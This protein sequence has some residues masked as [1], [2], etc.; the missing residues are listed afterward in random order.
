[1]TVN[2]VAMVSMIIVLDEEASADEFERFMLLEL[3]PTVDTGGE[4]EEPD[5]H[6]LLMDRQS[7]R[8]YTWSARLNYSI[9]QTPTPDWLLNRVRD[10]HAAASDRVSPFGTG[11]S[12]ALLFDVAGWRR[13]LGEPT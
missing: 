10:M 1:M 8:E 13:Q 7:S 4:G 9:H 12:G 5:Q 6:V 2:A 11:T 3:F